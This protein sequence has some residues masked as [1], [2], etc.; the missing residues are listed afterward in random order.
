MGG[1][2]FDQEA[3]RAEIMAESM[4]HACEPRFGY[5]GYTSPLAIGDNSGQP[6]KSKFTNFKQPN[7][8]AHATK[9]GGT[10]DTYFWFITPMAVGDPY[11]M[12]K[13]R[14]MQ[15]AVKLKDGE[16]PFRPGGLMQWGL[17]QGI[18]Y[19]GTGEGDGSRDSR[20]RQR[21]IPNI[22]PNI[23]TSITKK[24]GGGV[25]TPGV[26]FGFGDNRAGL[27]EHIPDPFDIK[28]QL[29]RAE[30]KAER[31]SKIHE[32]GFRGCGYGNGTFSSSQE[33]YK[34]DQPYGIP[35]ELMKFEP[36]KVSHEMPMKLGQKVKTGHD[37]C[38]SPY[39]EWMPD[40]IPMP[41][42]RIHK[43]EKS[44][45]EQWRVGAPSEHNN[46]QPAIQMIDRN[47]R[48][49]FPASFRRPVP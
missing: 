1:G 11:I 19:G 31:D 32:V 26:L 48:R 38:C 35:R 27:P 18:V 4:E 22:Q 42:K 15:P 47:L 10:V 36:A 2:A 16:Q 21:V 14:A 23:V 34:C 8:Q 17:S 12:P 39:P 3:R 49:E 46:P 25:Y 9:K 43:G 5:F 37:A 6:L 20:K 24:G 33:S 7:I 28:S 41:R 29:R 13:N 30:M 40:P 44:D 45:Q